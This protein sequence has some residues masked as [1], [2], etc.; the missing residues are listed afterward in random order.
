MNREPTQPPNPSEQATPDR[1]V[2]SLEVPSVAALSAWY[3]LAGRAS[4]AVASRATGGLAWS[5]R[6]PPLQGV[7]LELTTGSDEFEV[8]PRTRLVRALCEWMPRQWA[9]QDREAAAAASLE[10]MAR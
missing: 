3:D 6:L 4:G 7:Q 2:I 9:L 8:L 1:Q 5:L 10:G